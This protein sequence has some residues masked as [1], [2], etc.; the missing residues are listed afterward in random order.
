MKTRKCPNCSQIIKYKHD[1]S[2]YKARKKNTLC[3]VCA[4][5]KW[6]QE[7]G[8][9]TTGENNPFFGKEHTELTKLHMAKKQKELRQQ[10]NNI[11]QS[12]EYR[13]KISKSSS[14]KNNPMYGKT[15][16]DVWVEKYGVEEADKKLQ[17]LKN[18]HQ[19][20]NSGCGNP[21]YGKPVPYGSGYGWKGWYKGWFFR[22]LREL[23]YMINVI[24]KNNYSWKSA[25]TQELSIPYID[26]KGTE[27][28]YRADF[29]INNDTLVEV[30]PKRLHNSPTV[31]L[32]IKGAKK[33]CK[34]MKLKYKLVDCEILSDIDIKTLFQSKK[35]KFT[36][37]YEQ[38]YKDMYL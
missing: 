7:T 3:S 6:R 22:S 21:M 26:W 29:L 12:Q 38:K 9:N 8:Y 32:K 5:K 24:E 11:Y 23:S 16:Y 30:K 15:V 25:E 36:D 37:K 4:T 14:G 31:L 27:R 34:K 2:F 33:F 20:N 18:K 19:Q 17:N 13:K 28:T 1:N 10:P 35:I